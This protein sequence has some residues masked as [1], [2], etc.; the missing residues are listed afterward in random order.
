MK[1]WETR[2]ESSTAYREIGPL[3]LM[4]TRSGRWSVMDS[5]NDISS[6]WASDLDAAKVAADAAC[7]KILREALADFGL[8]FIEAPNRPNPTWRALAVDCELYEIIRLRHG[9]FL[10]SS[11]FH[12]GEECDT[13]ELAIAEARV[14][15]EERLKYR[16][17]NDLHHNRY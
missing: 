10:C 14:H 4:A 8:V 16:K 12:E 3:F 1:N 2:E 17:N 6:G 15:D 5:D 9:K 11:R 7:E 13:L